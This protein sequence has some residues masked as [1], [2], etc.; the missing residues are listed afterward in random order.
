VL[1]RENRYYGEKRIFERVS[2]AGEPWT[3][4]I[5]EGEVEEF[6]A[7]RGFRVIAHQTPA[8][9]EKTYLTDEN[10]VS[11]GRVNGTHAVVTA[12]VNQEA[13]L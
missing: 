12:C 8:D 2:K 6:L 10:G 9:L 1:R 5:E 3:F 13:L 11:L 4:G 7:E